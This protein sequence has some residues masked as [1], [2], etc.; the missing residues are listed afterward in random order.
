[1]HRFHQSSTLLVDIAQVSPADYITV[2]TGQ[3]SHEKFHRLVRTPLLMGSQTQMMQSNRL[4][5]IR[6]NHLSVQTHSRAH[7]ARLM[8]GQCIPQLVRDVTI[9]A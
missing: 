2:I 6:G 7:I 5:R 9:R 1:V 3:G 8:T 4:T